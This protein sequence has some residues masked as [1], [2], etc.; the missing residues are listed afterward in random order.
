MSEQVTVTSMCL[1]L[2]NMRVINVESIKCV[3]CTGSCSG[4]VRCR[5]L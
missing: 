4:C 2:Y 1:S 3:E 5:R